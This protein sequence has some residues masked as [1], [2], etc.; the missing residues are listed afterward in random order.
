MR[1]WRAS[2]S[3]TIVENSPYRDFAGIISFPAQNFL[4][5]LTPASRCGAVVTRRTCI[6]KQMRRSLVQ[7]WVSAQRP[8]FLHAL[9]FGHLNLLCEVTMFF[10][11]VQCV[12]ILIYE[13]TTVAANLLLHILLLCEVE[14]LGPSTF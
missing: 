4:N 13:Y 7:F 12:K 5:S 8:S 10:L 14:F 3:R 9:F 1:A 2:R 11:L 6:F